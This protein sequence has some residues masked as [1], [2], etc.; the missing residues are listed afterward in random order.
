MTGIGTRDVS[1]RDRL[2]RERPVPSLARCIEALRASKLSTVHKEQ[3]MDVCDSAHTIHASDKR[4]L[5][6]NRKGSGSG[7]KIRL[8]DGSMVT[9]LGSYTFTV[10][11]NSGSKCKIK[12]DILE[13]APWPVVDGET[14][15]KQ[16][17]ISLSV[18]QSVHSVN[19]KHYEPLAL[20]ELVKEYEDVFTGLGCFSGEYHIKVDTNIAPAQHVPRRV[21]VP[22]KGKLKTKIEE[23]EKQGIIVKET[24]PTEWIS[25]LVAV[26]KPGKSRV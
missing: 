21:L 18:V 4:R 5:K 25:S 16:G 1:T 26:Q 19:S 9:P 20:D 23:M 24:G 13:N 17:W 7:G 12:F 22:L 14:C 8:Y 6:E 3:F 11:Q 2:L 15:I 10:S